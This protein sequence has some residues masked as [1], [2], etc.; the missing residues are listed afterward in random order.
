MRQARPMLDL[1][2][3]RKPAFTGAAIVAFCLSASMFAMFLYLTLYV[4]NALGYSPLE[5]GVRFLPITLVSFVVAPIAGK[6]SARI[7]VRVLLGAGMALVGVGLLLMSGLDAHSEWTAL[8]DGFLVAGAGIGMVNPSLASTA[9][10]VV[11]PQRSGM[12]SGISNTFRQVGIATGIAG[13]GALFQH[14]L[15]TSIPDKVGPAVKHIPVEALASGDPRVIT[16]GVT[17][18]AADALGTA[19]LAGY[20]H[21]LN[22]ILVVGAVVAFVGAVCGLA[23]VR[24]RDFVVA[25]TP[26]AAADG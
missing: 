11:L 24:R 21:A 20:T 5:A 12:A 15:S 26:S 4:Q 7:P 10:G 17:A 25:W 6:L 19:Y 13:L 14:L 22:R 9:V 2:L 8:L 16:H 23:L 18:P 1:A 3:F